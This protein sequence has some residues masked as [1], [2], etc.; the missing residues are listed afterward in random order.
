ME[1][2]DAIIIQ[3]NI[4]NLEDSEDSG[5]FSM[6]HKNFRKI[7]WFLKRWNDILKAARQGFQA[8]FKHY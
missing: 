3:C 8:V 4:Y 6:N 5:R 7:E 1:R 2:N